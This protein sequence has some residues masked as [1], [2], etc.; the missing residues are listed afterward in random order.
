MPSVSIAPQ[1]T[2]CL[3]NNIVDNNWEGLSAAIDLAGGSQNNRF[4]YNNIIGTLPLADFE[5][6]HGSNIWDDTV[7]RGNYWS[8]YTGQD[9]NENGIG[10]IPLVLTDVNPVNNDNYP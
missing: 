5:T 7:S 1:T 2:E 9:A 3:E 6:S 4:Y 10:D 8:S